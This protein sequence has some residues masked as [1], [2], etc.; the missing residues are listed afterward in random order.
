MKNELTRS[1]DQYYEELDSIARKYRTELHSTKTDRNLS[2]FGKEKKEE[3]LKGELLDKLHNLRQ[4]FN[5]DLTER[6]ENIEQS[7]SPPDY[8][9]L[10]V[11]NIRQKLTEG[12]AF[13]GQES[14]FFALLGSI[15]DLREDL[16]KSTFVS[17]VSRL[18]NE[19]MG[20]IFE[21]AAEKE[22]TRRLEWIKDAAVLSGRE[23]EAF[24]KSVDAQ[25]E[26][27]NDEKLTSEQRK[28]KMTASELQ[29]QKE[30]FN[31]SMEKTISNDGEFVDLREGEDHIT[32]AEGAEDGDL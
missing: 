5:H 1:V 16:H 6:L 19:D 28:L 24:L 30:L 11:R 27:I 15:D 12:E 20:R 29:K 21:H 8:R 4:S 3:A 25:I 9:K 22:D 31:Y 13:L 14:L 26:T 10:R 18:S 32:D 23:S 2:G 7:V 17:S